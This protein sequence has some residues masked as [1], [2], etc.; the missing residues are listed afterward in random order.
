MILIMYSC[1]G[2]GVKLTESFK[3]CPKCGQANT[4]F[5]DNNQGNFNN[6]NKKNIHYLD[7]KKINH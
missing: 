3:F 1:S 7:I 4:I 5:L 6:E 2:C